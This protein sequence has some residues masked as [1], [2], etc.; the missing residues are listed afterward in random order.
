MNANAQN[1]LLKTLENPPEDA[2][3][4]L[5]TE[6]AESMLSTILSRCQM[7]RFAPLTTDQCADVLK[8]KGIDADRAAQLAGF[9]QGSVGRALEIDADENYLSLRGKVIES[10]NALR[11]DASVAK[12]ASL[13]ADEDS[14]AALE[15]MELWARDLMVSQNGQKPYEASDESRLRAFKVSGSRLLNSVMDA[16]R[17][18]S[19]NVSWINVLES[20]YFELSS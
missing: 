12:A 7:V 13:L 5:L 3:F 8:Q 9:A 20:M 17:K 1:A 14:T 10:L 18:L 4:F 2:M 16:R 11:G 19:S 6:S 15:I